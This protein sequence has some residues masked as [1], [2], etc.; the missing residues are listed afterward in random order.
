[1]TWTAFVSTAVCTADDGWIGVSGDRG[2]KAIAVGS[3]SSSNS[4]RVAKPSHSRSLGHDAAGAHFECVCVLTL[5]FSHPASISCQLTESEDVLGSR[6]ASHFS[7]ATE[8]TVEA[9]KLIYGEWQR[10]LVV[11]IDGNSCYVNQQM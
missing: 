2:G 1:M 3:R 4:Q 6:T 5:V 10:E 8:K 11:E 7:H 9:R